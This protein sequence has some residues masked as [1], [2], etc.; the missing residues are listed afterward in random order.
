MTSRK[1]SLYAVAVLAALVGSVVITFTSL[2]DAVSASQ[3]F[4]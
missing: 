3:S 4:L 1:T 2:F